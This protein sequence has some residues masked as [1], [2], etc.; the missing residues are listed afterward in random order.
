MTRTKVEVSPARPK[1][2]PTIHDFISQLAVFEK[3]P[4]RVLA[5]HETLSKT[6]GLEEE[7]TAE[8]TS[9]S[10]TQLKQGQFAKCVIAH[11]EGKAVGFSIFFY[12]YSTVLS[13]PFTRVQLIKLKYSG[14][15]LL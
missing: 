1:D 13:T 15:L 11:A 10:A 8:E 7:P 4:E 9:I 2:V 5:T 3:C 6:L 12:N 14:Y